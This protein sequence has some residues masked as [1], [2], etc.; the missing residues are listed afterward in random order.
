MN[1]ALKET[2]SIAVQQRYPLLYWTTMA[3]V[4]GLPNFV[5]FDQTGR[6]T[7]Q[8]NASSISL[9]IQVVITGYVLV[10]M[11]LLDWRPI[12]ARKIRFDGGLWI[13]LLLVFVLATV[14]QPVS[15]SVPTT[16][17][18]LFLSLFRLGQW[19]IAFVLIVALY[20]RTAPERATGLVVELIGRSSWIWLAMVWL[21]L[22]IV[23]AQVYGGS[24]DGGSDGIRRLGG[25]LIH[26]AHVALFGSIAFFYALLFLARGPRKWISCL[27]ALVTIGLTGARTQQAG[28]LLALVL[29][30]IVL[31]RKPAMRWGTIA[32]AALA[33]LLCLPLGDSVIRYIGRG[34]SAQTLASLDDRTRVWAVSFD[35]IRERPFLGYGYSVGARNA[36]RDH[37]TFGHWIPPHA[38]NEFI[39]VALDGGIFT[40]ALVFCIYGRVLLTSIREAHRGPPHLFL[41]VVFVQFALETLT[42]PELGYGYHGTGAILVLCCVGVLDGAAVKVRQY[43]IVRHTTPRPVNSPLREYSA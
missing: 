10:M 32:V 28:F 18:A 7:N 9:V 1:N 36:I 34:Q 26:P 2:S 12:S 15:R 40:L 8:I 4:V 19:V 33:F 3:Y 37:W 6:T 17:M 39:Q 41:L 11:L 42:G 21:L 31:S 13:A 25:Q 16:S 5:H 43:R 20:S 23:P 30:A 27:I 38:H 24:E 14:F 29:Y 35:A 22:P